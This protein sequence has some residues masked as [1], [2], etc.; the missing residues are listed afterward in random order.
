MN[1]LKQA[2]GLHVIKQ[3]IGLLVS[4]IIT[5]LIVILSIIRYGLLKPLILIIS[6][7]AKT[8]AKMAEFLL[9]LDRKL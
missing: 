7:V 5:L 3:A 9:Y 6:I 1:R 8:F 4:F 2:S